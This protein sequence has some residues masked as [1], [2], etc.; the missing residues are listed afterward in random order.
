VIPAVSFAPA[1]TLNSGGTSPAAVVSGDFNGDNII[2]LAVA[3][4][5][6]GVVS[7]LPGLGN[8]N[9][10]SPINTT[11]PAGSTPTALGVGDFNGDG[12]LDLLVADPG[13]SAVRVLLGTGNGTFTPGQVISFPAG[14]MPGS[15]AVGDINRDGKLDFVAVTSA[16]GV[17]TSY[18]GNGDGTFTATVTSLPVGTN[19]QDVVLAD[20]TGDGLL[21]ALVAVTGSDRV[22]VMINNSIVPG[23]YTAGTSVN[24]TAGSGPVSIAT[25][26]FDTGATVDFAV[27]N[28]TA[29]NVQTFFGTGTG[30]FT[31]GQTINV[32]STSLPTGIVAASFSGAVTPDLAVADA[33]ANNVLVLTNNGSGTFSGPTSAL[34]LATGTTP[35]ALAAA[36]LNK[37]GRIDLIS[38]NSGSNTLS[39]FQNQNSPVYF[40]VGSGPGVVSQVTLFD[41]N[42]NMIGQ[43]NPF[44]GLNFTGGIRVAIGDVI[45]DSTPDLVMTTGAG[46]ISLVFIYDGA[47]LLANPNNPSPARAFNPFGS[48]FFGGF[49]VAVGRLDGKAKG[50]LILG[51]DA[52]GGPQVNI[53]SNAQIQA[54]N[55]TTPA[56]QFFAY[57]FGGGLFFTGGVRVASAD[58]NGDGMDDV[59]TGAGK[60]GGPQVNIYYGANNASF[61][62]SGGLANLAFFAFGPALSFFT[63]GIFV[64]AADFDGSAKADVIV[65]ADSGGGPEVTVFTGTQ[66]TASSPNVNPS[67]AFFA[68]P[69]SFTGGVR[70]GSAVAAF[71]SANQGRALTAAP[72]PG[73]VSVVSLFNIFSI[74]NGGATN[75]FLSVTVPP[76]VATAGLYVS[77]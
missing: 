15:L 21:D 12:K 42:G 77:V 3:N 44:V 52:G 33:G 36:D 22:A 47:A 30:L 59:I 62:Q 65:G 55:F 31:P 66:L 68:Q 75:P 69:S 76:V 70:V 40:A 61:L 20:V 11:L 58:V 32:G 38:A 26:N 6:G 27:A 46:G 73:G 71:T 29:G 4:K 24:L 51:A 14:S 5:T 67:A 7:V 74:L 25:G 2:D 56:T 23:N 39:V 64:T 57:P 41:Q 49:F 34:T 16:T 60:G 45:G 13:S 28:L 1:L 72:G 17:F 18:L 54:A 48:L 35:V 8:G 37:D 9:F 19:P 50:E 10:G 43:F 63:G 53:Y